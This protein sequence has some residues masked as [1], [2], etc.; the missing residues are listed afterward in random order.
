MKIGIFSDIHGNLP[1][2]NVVIDFLKKKEVNTFI[3]CGDIVGYGPYPNEVI[4]VLENLENFYS[5]CGNHDWAVLG[6]ED[7][8]RL[9]ENARKAIL[10]TKSVLTDDKR[11]FLA[12]LEMKLVGSNFIIVH[13]SL[14]DPLEEYVTGP[15]VYAKS[16]PKQ[17]RRIVFSGHTHQPIYYTATST[18]LITPRFFI[19]DSPVDISGEGDL[20]YL[21]NVGSVGQP[22]DGNPF[23]A[24]VI[25]DTKE[26]KVTLYRL[27]YPVK[28]VQEKM[29]EVGLPQFL[30][31][32]IGEGV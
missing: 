17:N 20:R 23:A 11:E 25:Y 31:D 5:V 4:D 12:N 15:D 9:N 27:E 30:I 14:N 13:G 2:L 6:L 3:C 16:L 18:G 21:I 1:A 26:K 8:N 28:E 24:C 10:W 19:P 22:R 32:R 7:L 29:K